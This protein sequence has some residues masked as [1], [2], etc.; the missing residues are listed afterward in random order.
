MKSGRIVLAEPGI[1]IIDTYG[2][3]PA[4]R[5]GCAPLLLPAIGVIILIVITVARGTATAQEPTPIPTIA[6]LPTVTATATATDT[7]TPTP[8]ATASPTSWPTLTPTN[9]PT[10]T[11][12]ATATLTPTVTLVP[13]VFGTVTGARELNVRYGPGTEWPTM[14]RG[15]LLQ[16]GA[17][18]RIIGRDNGARWGQID[19]P[20]DGGWVSMA[21]IQSESIARLPVVEALPPVRDR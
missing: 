17:T 11:P 19:D 18:V 13:W 1:D 10:V 21:Y 2:A 12:T 20:F 14:G 7:P 15:N 6:G 16:E 5:G 3:Q 4:P 9:T 8:T